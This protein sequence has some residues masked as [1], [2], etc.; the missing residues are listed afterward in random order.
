M[1]TFVFFSRNFEIKTKTNSHKRCN[2]FLGLIIKRQISS[3]FIQKVSRGA[4]KFVVKKRQ[5]SSLKNSR[6]R[7]RSRKSSFKS[8]CIVF[9][10]VFNLGNVFQLIWW[11]LS[12]P[13]MRPGWTQERMEEWISNMLQHWNQEYYQLY[14][15]EDIGRFCSNN[16]IPN[17][18]HR[19]YFSEDTI[20]AT[21]DEYG[22]RYRSIS[23]F[24]ENF[25]KVDENSRINDLLPKNILESVKQARFPFWS[26]YHEKNG[27]DNTEYEKIKTPIDSR[28]PRVSLTLIFT[29]CFLR[30]IGKK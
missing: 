15:Y 28:A 29:N 19:W 8:H 12:L 26:T 6:L 3:I 18:D 21:I 13:L 2:N 27:L 23:E 24:S 30:K 5:N 16:H 4:R 10:G 17:I 9:C 1:K 7:P 14:H 11:S 22:N 20:K 25:N